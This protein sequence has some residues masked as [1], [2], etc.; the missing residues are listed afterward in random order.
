M[1]LLLLF[2]T[3]VN[4]DIVLAETVALKRFGSYSQVPSN[5]SSAAITKLFPRLVTR[6]HWERK[7]EV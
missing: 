1:T 7:L 2:F 4:V 6:P 3:D 5:V